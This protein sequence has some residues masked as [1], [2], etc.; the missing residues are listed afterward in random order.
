MNDW[1]LK[2][3]KQDVALSEKQRKQ[4]EITLNW[5]FGYCSKKQL[6]D[7]GERENGRVFWR[8]AVSPRRAEQWQRDGWANAMKWFFNQVVDRDDAGRRLRSVIRLRHLSYRTELAYM[9][10]LR[11]F[12]GFIHPADVLEATADQVVTFLSHLAEVECI[13]A[14][15]QSQAFNALLFYFRHVL[16][17]K[18]V[19]FEGATRACKRARVP[20]VLSAKEVGALM[21]ELDEPF[22]LM[23]RVQYG[24]GLR[25]SELLRLRVKDLDFERG[26]LIVRGGKGDKDRATVLP[27][28]LF[29]VLRARLDRIK[30]LYAEDLGRG[31]SGASMPASLARKFS[32]QRK[33]LQWQYVFPSRQL[34][35]D[36]RSGEWLR[37]HALANSYQVSVSRAAAKAGI[38]KRVTPHVLRHSF[39]THLLEAGADIR[40]V[41]EL[42]GHESVETTQIYTHVMKR[43]HGVVSPL[44]RLG[45]GA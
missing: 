42:L 35:K 9:G 45:G 13:A 29:E 8:E 27:E 16:G 5:Y 31:F 25:I 10:W 4:Y 40:T 30:G 32:Q 18:T 20:V 11:R 2:L 36:P 33:S 37:H 28:S 43:P 12:Q 1:I 39:A 19:V 17:E 3:L 24:A 34:G 44:D 38:E 23:A 41:Q 7:P 22:Q 15:S 26:Q 21:G 6:G 14:S